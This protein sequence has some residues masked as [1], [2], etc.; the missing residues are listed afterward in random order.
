MSNRAH[1]DIR[2]EQMRPRAAE[3]DFMLNVGRK[4]WV[5]GRYTSA[6]VREEGNIRERSGESRRG[7]WEGGR[8]GE[9]EFPLAH[10]SSASSSG[11]CS[12]GLTISWRWLASVSTCTCGRRLAREVEPS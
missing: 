4:S 8:N 10:I 6:R 11:A 1:M 2:E 3:S 7:A 12:L 5:S 9:R